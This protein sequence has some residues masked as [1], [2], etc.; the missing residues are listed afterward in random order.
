MNFVN[1]LCSFFIRGN[2]SLCQLYNSFVRKKKMP[3]SSGFATRLFESVDI[4]ADFEF[5]GIDQPEWPTDSSGDF[6]M[7]GVSA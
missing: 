2:I 7:N 3:P 1:Q 6:T 5:L 4:G